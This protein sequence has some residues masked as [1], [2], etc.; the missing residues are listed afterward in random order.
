MYTTREFF[1]QHGG[2]VWDRANSHSPEKIRAM[3]MLADLAPH[4]V[5]LDVGCGTG[6]LEPYLLEYR[7]S[8][9][10]GV[11]FAQSMIESAREKLS[12]SAVRFVCADIFDVTDLACDCCFLY[13]TFQHFPDPRA[14]LRHI[15]TL[16]RP[17]GRLMISH[18][19]SKRILPSDQLP[20]EF[21]PARTLRILFEDL[22]H[23]DTIID[24]N[25]MFLV[26]GLKR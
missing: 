20:D 1:D 7:P 13:N 2:T 25:A 17:G 14:A 26:S 11:D 18:S 6:I 12:H 5:I 9:I 22:Y 10:M 16:L 24:S 4:S 23:V 8:V 19:Q 3:L 21:H 15:T